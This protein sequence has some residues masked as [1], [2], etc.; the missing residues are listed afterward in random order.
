MQMKFRSPEG[1]VKATLDQLLQQENIVIEYWTVKKRKLEQCHQFVLFEQSAKQ[2]G[3]NISLFSLSACFAVT[4]FHW[5][6]RIA[7]LKQNF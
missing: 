7:V 4:F 3:V 1:H 2:V 6:F 5:K